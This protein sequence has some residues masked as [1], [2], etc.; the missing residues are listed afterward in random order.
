MSEERTSLTVSAHDAP[1]ALRPEIA[2]LVDVGVLAR[3]AL[4]DGAR[5]MV[6]F[7][8]LARAATRRGVLTDAQAALLGALLGLGG[9]GAA[10]DL[11]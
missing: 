5:D 2:R 9:T 10:N 3:A 1:P 7:D 4:G 11:A 6:L 8:E